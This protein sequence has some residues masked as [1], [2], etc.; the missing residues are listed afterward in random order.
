MGP[1]RMAKACSL[2]NMT[3]AHGQVLLPGRHGLSA[4]PRYAA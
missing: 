3:L 1:K 2:G 4:L